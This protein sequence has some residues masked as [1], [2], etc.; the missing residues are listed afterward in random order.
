MEGSQP[1]WHYACG[2]RA[3]RNIAFEEKPKVPTSNLASMGVYIFSW[4][5]LQQYL[6][7]DE[8]NRLSGNDFGK[9]IIPAMLQDGVKLYAYHVRWVLEGC[10][11][12]GELMGSQ[13]GFAL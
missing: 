9:D 7:R 11:Y 10:R 4:P 2:C 12:D 13:Y 6:I 3:A 5:V 1:F 8:A